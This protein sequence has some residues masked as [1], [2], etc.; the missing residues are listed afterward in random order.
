MRILDSNGRFKTSGYFLKDSCRILSLLH[1]S[2]PSGFVVST[3]FLHTKTP[4]SRFRVGGT[5]R[6][7]TTNK[8]HVLRLLLSCFPISLSSS[9][10]WGWSEKLG[11]FLSFQKNIMSLGKLVGGIAGLPDEVC[12]PDNIIKII[13]SSSFKRQTLPLIRFE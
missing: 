3:V 9:S 6:R 10:W 4:R 7:P 8:T 13:Y 5:W 2:L 12:P 1:S 11:N